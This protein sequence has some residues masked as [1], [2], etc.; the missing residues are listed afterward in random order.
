[1]GSSSSPTAA[2]II[3][4]NEILSGR[5]QDKNLNYLASQLVDVGIRFSEA[6]V[7][8]DIEVEIVDAVN[9]LRKRYTYVF[10][11]GGI[12]P[13]HDDITTACVAKAFEVPVVIYPEALAVLEGYYLE[14]D[15]SITELN[16]GQRKMAEVPEGARLIENSVTSAPGYVMENVYVLAGIPKIMQAMFDALKPQLLHGTVVHS[17][18][19]TVEHSESTIAAILTTFQERFPEIEIGSY[20]FVKD[21]QYAVNVVLRSE[22][23]TKLDSV[24]EE[25]T[26]LLSELKR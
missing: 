17:R 25:L 20:P 16:A 19:L 18:E 24:K 12:G 21:G 7:V 13:T 8:P 6:R 14:R 2:L 3:I 5:T 11:T 9:V 22:N 15:P 4:G 1:M 10:T 23:L 26:E